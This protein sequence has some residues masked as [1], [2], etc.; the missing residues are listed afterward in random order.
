[1]HIKNVK[2]IYLYVEDVKVYLTS[3]NVHLYIE[4]IYLDM[5]CMLTYPSNLVFK[6]CQ[7]DWRLQYVHI[8][9]PP[10]P[11]RRRYLECKPSSNTGGSPSASSAAACKRDKCKLP[12]MATTTSK[13]GQQ[14]A[15]EF[16]S[17][18]KLLSSFYRPWHHQKKSAYRLK[19]LNQH[20]IPDGSWVSTTPKPRPK[21]DKFIPPFENWNR[22][23]RHD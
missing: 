6:Y 20:G 4:S 9:A 13:R 3:K 12:G 1:M 18:I 2:P 17:H 7:V 23:G 22:H 10:F 19:T 5:L 8:V 16:E 14:T 11:W 15:W 21:K